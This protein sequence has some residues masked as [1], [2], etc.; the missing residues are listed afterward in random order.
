MFPGKI[1]PRQMKKMM[2]Q[3]GMEM[4]ELPAREVVIKL[5]DREI[6]IEN[7][8]VNVIRAMGQKTYQIAG[9]ERELVAVPEEDVRLVAEQ[10]GVSPDEAREALKKTGGDLAEA[11]MLLT[12]E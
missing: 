5:E 11:I 8:T 12:R 1:N 9:E 4:E 10:A 3:L 7:P 6:V 2:K